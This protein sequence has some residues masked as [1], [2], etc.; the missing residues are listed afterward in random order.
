MASSAASHK[1]L[2]SSAI[3]W[4]RKLE[5]DGIDMGWEF[6]GD[7]VRGGSP[8]DKANFNSLYVPPQTR[9][10]LT[11]LWR[12]SVQEF[13]AAAD[14]DAVSAGNPALILTMAAPAGPSD[15]A[16]IDLKTISDSLDW[17]RTLN[18]NTAAFMAIGTHQAPILDQHLAN[19][20]FNSAINMYLDAGVPPKKIVAGPLPS[21]IFQ[22]L[23][24]YDRV[25]TLTDPSQNMPGSPGTAG[26]AGRRTGQPG[27]LSYFEIAEIRDAQKGTGV[28]W[29][30]GT[31]ITWYALDETFDYQ[32]VGYDDAFSF[33][34]KVDIINQKS[35]GG[36]MLWAIDQDTK[37]MN[38]TKTLIR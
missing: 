4:A 26:V 21:S 34:A 16:N 20:S 36:V 3:A 9:L 17:L 2:I 7:R 32:W 25:W 22:G 33:L 10:F 12:N 23:P 19:W 11:D 13:R 18:S 37:D 28:N 5:F 27:Y 35:L 31:G 6:I 24:L 8:A 1:T 15:I 30:S 38:L 14:A 29:V